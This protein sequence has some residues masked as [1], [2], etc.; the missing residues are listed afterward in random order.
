MLRERYVLT[1][2]KINVYKTLSDVESTNIF[3]MYITLTNGIEE[4]QE[5]KRK[6]SHKI[7]LFVQF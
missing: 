5:K 2:T 1:R 4:K 6:K 7:F 3:L